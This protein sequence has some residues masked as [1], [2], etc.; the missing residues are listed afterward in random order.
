M[1]L[2]VYSKSKKNKKREGS[3]EVTKYIYIYPEKTIILN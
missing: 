3:Q 2:K 1:K